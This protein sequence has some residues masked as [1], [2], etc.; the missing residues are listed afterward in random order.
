MRQGRSIEAAAA[1]L[2][3]ALVMAMLALIFYMVMR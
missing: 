3:G 1:P 2:V